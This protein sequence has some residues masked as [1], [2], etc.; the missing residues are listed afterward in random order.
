M[1][2]NLMPIAHMIQTLTSQDLSL[3]HSTMLI[4]TNFNGL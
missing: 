4:V 2:S 3:A 1:E